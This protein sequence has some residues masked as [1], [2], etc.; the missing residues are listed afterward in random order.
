MIIHGTVFYP[1]TAEIYYATSVQNDIGRMVK[2]WRF[3]RKV[4]CSAIKERAEYNAKNAVNAEKTL[5]YTEKINFRCGQNILESASGVLYRPTDVLVAH[6]KDPK[7]RYTWLENNNQDTSFE[8]EST[9]VMFDEHHN[10]GGYRSLL[11]RSQD[12]VTTNV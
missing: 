5:I 1:M 4:Y 12:Q 6:I 8:I 2:T 9:E 10:I 11:S 7:G 3:D